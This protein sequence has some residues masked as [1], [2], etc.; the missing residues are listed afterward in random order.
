MTT[1]T[2]SDAQETTRNAEFAMSSKPER[3]V[4]SGHG[5]TK[6][7]D[8]R[9]LWRDLDVSF[10]PGT[11]SSVTGESGSGKTTLLNAL[12]L[13]EP[14][15]SGSIR[16][17]SQRIDT[18]KRADVRKLYRDSI[19]FLF[20]N[21]A[22]VEQWNV[23]RNLQLALTSMGVV[24]AERKIRIRQALEA[25][26]LVGRESSAVYT[27]S[28]GEQQRLAIARLMAHRPR[29][30]LADEPTAALD[31]D[32]C[33]KI[34]RYLRLIADDGAIVVMTTHNPELADRAD[35]EYRLGV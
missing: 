30:V 28:G 23:E 14:L 9:T 8:G 11:I 34:M 21:Y 29:V 4:L 1:D 33:D 17:G 26:G 2:K 6:V 13:L 31:P 5:L 24:K 3:A 35:K 16:L 7:I 19:G 22:L 20:Q 18:L 25:V 15:T 12:G 10:E 32:N 27:L